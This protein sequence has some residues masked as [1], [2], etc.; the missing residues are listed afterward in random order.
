MVVDRMSFVTVTRCRPGK[1][2]MEEERK[3]K[4]RIRNRKGR[5]ILINETTSIVAFLVSMMN[6][7]IIIIII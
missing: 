6:D 5:T 7:T 1:E 3:G 2:R 4:E